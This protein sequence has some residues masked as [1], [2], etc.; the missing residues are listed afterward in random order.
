ML[1]IRYHTCLY[2]LLT[3]CAH[4][5]LMIYRALKCTKLFEYFTPAEIWRVILM[6]V[7]CYICPVPIRGQV[8]CYH[9]TVSIW[10]I[11]LYGILHQVQ[12]PH[13]FQCVY[14][15]YFPCC[16]WHFTSGISSHR[17]QAISR[18]LELLFVM[19]S[20][21]IS[22][23][24]LLFAINAL[25]RFDAYT[26]AWSCFWFVCFC[27]FFW[28]SCYSFT[29]PMHSAKFLKLCVL[30]VQ[31]VPINTAAHTHALGLVLPTN[32]ITINCIGLHCV[33]IRCFP[34]LK[35]FNSFQLINSGSKGTFV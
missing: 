6:W 25:C 4:V 9:D 27:S 13:N 23:T 19:N 11:H 17:Y 35:R 32:Y 33:I 30:C 3:F 15:L 10:Y 28:L 12:C 2:I 1:L 5:A 7:L 14:L 26:A 29:L 16:N 22:M 31:T 21:N 34:R 18:I 8:I 24:L 20:W